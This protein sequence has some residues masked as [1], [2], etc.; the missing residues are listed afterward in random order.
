MYANEASMTDATVH[1]VVVGLQGGKEI[2]QQKVE[3]IN[4][5]HENLADVFKEAGRYGPALGPAALKAGKYMMRMADAAKN[6][7]FGYIWGVQVLYTLGHAISEDIKK[8]ADSGDIDAAGESAAA[9][10]RISGRTDLPGLLAL[11][12]ETAAEVG[13]EYAQER[14]A[15]TRHGEADTQTAYGHRTA[16]GVER[17]PAQ[18]G[19]GRPGRSRRAR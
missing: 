3:G 16:H 7:G 6:L 15:H 9:V 19:H 8:R 10:T 14:A 12:M 2:D 1:H 13:R 4:A 11:A 5:V 18:P 17:A